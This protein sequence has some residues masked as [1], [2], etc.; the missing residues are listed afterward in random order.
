MSTLPSVE[1]P[2][3]SVESTSEVA[4]EDIWKEE[5]EEQ[6]KAWRNQSAEA[7][8]KAEKV[9]EQWEIKRAAERE[10]AA[11]RKAA[12]FPEPEPEVI[13][14]PQA[15]SVSES[16]A[17]SAVLVPSEKEEAVKTEENTTVE[18]PAPSPSPAD[19]R[20]LVTGEPQGRVR[21][22][23]FDCSLL[24]YEGVILQVASSTISQPDT[25]D[26]SQKWEE[27]NSPTTSYPSMSFP[28]QSATPPLESDRDNHRQTHSQPTSAP[29]TATLSV[30]DTSLSPRM[31]MKAFASS[32][33]INL[34]LPF[35]NGVM[36]GFGEI[37]AKNFVLG[38]L[39]WGATATNVGISQ[40]RSGRQAGLR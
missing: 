37:F 39:G 19:V 16:M 40:R 8:E 6:V 10:E 3:T 18:D 26:G 30:F 5:Y 1:P 12:G 24:A 32:L 9:R 27:V 38:W 22:F 29:R 20:N 28:E 31:R 23:A 4:G 7:R 35:V 15:G 13:P 25:I 36:L 17:S 14:G 21:S 33:A 2:T 34:L 11:K